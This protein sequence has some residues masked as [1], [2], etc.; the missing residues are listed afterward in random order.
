MGRPHL[1]FI[2]ASGDAHVVGR[3]LGAASAHALREVVPALD[4]F[5]ALQREWS[6]TDRVRSL[7]AAARAAWPRYVRE[8]EGIADGAGIAFE[9]VFLWNC[10]GDLPRGGSEGAAGRA[11]AARR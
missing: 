8:I 4:R 3:A 11:L 9:T 2:T 5:R 10:R 6:G 7:E 1:G